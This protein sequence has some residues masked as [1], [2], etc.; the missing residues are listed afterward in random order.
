MQAEALGQGAALSLSGVR[1]AAGDG[2]RRGGYGGR[3]RRGTE[4]SAAAERREVGGGRVGGSATRSPRLTIASS[5]PAIATT[6]LAPPPAPPPLVASSSLHLAPPHRATRAHS[7]LLLAQTRSISV[8]HLRKRTRERQQLCNGTSASSSS[9]SD[10]AGGGSVGA[11]EA[12]DGQRLR[13]VCGRAV[14][15]GTRGWHGEQHDRTRATT[16]MALSRR[17]FGRHPPRRPKL[18]I[19]PRATCTSPPPPLRPPPT[20]RRHACLVAAS[21]SALCLRRP[22]K[23]ESVC[24]R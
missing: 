9:L 12:V 13:R 21:S 15:G 6:E 24:E 14:D 8:R 16:A 20:R 23:R 4:A 19:S 17:V 10:G 22:E 1:Q 5:S 3:A 2:R 18:P 7:A 11:G